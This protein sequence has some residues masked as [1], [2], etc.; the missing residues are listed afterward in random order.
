MDILIGRIKV[1]FHIRE[2]PIGDLDRTGIDLY[3]DLDSDGSK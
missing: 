3:R 2:D 1:E